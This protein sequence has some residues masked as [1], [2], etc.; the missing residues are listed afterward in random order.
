MVTIS[1]VQQLEDYQ[2]KE[3]EDEQLFINIYDLD[4][5]YIYEMNANWKEF[6][7]DLLEEW[8]KKDRL[9]FGGYNE[10]LFDFLK[11][12]YNNIIKENHLKI[13]IRDYINLTDYISLEAWE[14]LSG[15]F[16]IKTDNGFYLVT[17][18]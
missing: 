10:S 15:N 9:Y 11:K 1:G 5:K 14:Q 18:A 3:L 17:L 13:D 4:L 6:F 8:S 16:L 7:F 2:V 12:N